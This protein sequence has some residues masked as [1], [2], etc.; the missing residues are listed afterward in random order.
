M[1]AY[2]IRRAT[3]DDIPSLIALRQLLFESIVDD[4]D[5]IEAMSRHSVQYF[6]RAIAHEDL[7]AWI[8]LDGAGA[9]VA[10]AVL[11]FYF[12]PPKPHNIEGKFGYLSSMYVVAQ[13][14]RKGIA[15]RLLQAVMDYAQEQGVHCVQLHASKVGKPLYASV[16][17]AELNEMGL[18]LE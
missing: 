6:Q 18:R 16:G 12:L 3:L 5:N 8:A 9:V 1:E 14:R 15:R 13:H 17:F 11:S 4:Q 10:S 7:A 2:P